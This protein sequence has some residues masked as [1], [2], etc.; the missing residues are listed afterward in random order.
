VGDLLVVPG[1]RRDGSGSRLSSPS[2]RSAGEDG[3][4]AG[5]VAVMRDVTA[6]FQETKAL[7]RQLGLAS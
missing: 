2:R 5:L 3:R 7:K 4:L 6:R 1:E